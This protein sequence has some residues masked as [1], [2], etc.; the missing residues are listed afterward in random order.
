MKRAPFLGGSAALLLSGCGGHHMMQA[1]PGVAPQGLFKQ[2]TSGGQLVP[3]VADPIPDNVLANPIIGEARRFDGSTAPTGWVF[4]QGQTLTVAQYPL[5]FS[6]LRS[7]AGGDGNTNFK[8]P[9][10]KFAMIVAVAGSFVRSPQALAQTGRHMTLKDS[11]GPSAVA[12]APRMAKA[13]SQQLLA[14]RRLITSGLRVGP[15]RPVSMSP[16][17]VARVAGAKADARTAAYEQLSATNRALLDSGVQRFLSGQIGLYQAVTEM[18]ASLTNSE[19]DAL[20]QV[21]ESMIRQFQS[22][23]DRPANLRD[24][25]S[26]Y[27]FSVTITNEQIAAATARGVDLR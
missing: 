27:L 2:P 25:A 20:F 4:A 5:L 14:E 11:L 23:G 7:V 21:R 19:A 15:P 13:P 18:A 6:V 10:P 3:Q 1:L 16:D 26:R 9:N 22:T 17:L 24:E 12:R 8:L